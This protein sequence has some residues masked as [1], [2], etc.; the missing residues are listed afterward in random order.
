M[1]EDKKEIEKLIFEFLKN[2]LSVET[3]LVTYS[4]DYGHEVEPYVKT[5]VY[6]TNPET[7]AQEKI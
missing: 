2:N 1:T 5:N 6:L 7:G 4:Q 3:E